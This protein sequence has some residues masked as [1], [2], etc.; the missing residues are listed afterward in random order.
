MARELSQ[1]ESDI[2]R[3]R[4]LLKIAENCER[5][6]EYGAR[7]FYEACQSFW[8]V[9]MLIQIES[10]G[11]SISPGRFDQY[12]YPYYKNDIVSGA[13][14]REFAQELMDCIWVKLNDLNKARDAASAEGFAGYSLFQNLIAGGQN[15]EGIDATND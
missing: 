7:N 1:K 14:T 3:S 8:F 6:P 12:M 11:H 2:V 13:I 5:V 9:Q 10:S 4:E 15:S